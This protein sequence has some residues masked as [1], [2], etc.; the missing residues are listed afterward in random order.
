MRNEQRRM[1]DGSTARVHGGRGRS[2]DVRELPCGLY[3]LG[4]DRLCGRVGV[5]DEQRRVFDEPA[6]RV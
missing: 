5:R 6:A 2:A 4:R 1:F 3:E